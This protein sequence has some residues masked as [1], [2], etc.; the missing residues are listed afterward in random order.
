MRRVFTSISAG[1]I[2]FTTAAIAAAQVLTTQGGRFAIDG[3]PGFLV[4]VS[5]FDALRR[6]PESLDSSVLDADLDYFAASGVSGI[7]V[8]PN[9]HV[10]NETLIDGSGNLRP[11]QLRKLEVLIGRAAAKRLVVDLSLTHDTVPGLTPPDYLRGVQ[12][13]AAALRGRTNVLFDLQ[14]ELDHH[15]P[16]ADARHPE[17]WTLHEWRAFVGNEIKTAVKQADPSRLVTVSW[18]SDR[19]PSELVA[20]L[21]DG[22]YDVL[23]YHHR[24]ESWVADSSAYVKTFESL[25]E[26]ARLERPIYFQEPA[27]RGLAG[28]PAAESDF[29]AALTGARDAGAAAWTLHVPA[30]DLSGTTPFR[31]LVSNT[32]RAVLSK[33]RAALSGRGGR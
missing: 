24:R 16:A 29:L 13:T 31:D 14:N 25:L 9:W 3:Q 15:V 17:Q 30:P 21:R 28:V 12:A 6:I 23:A 5:Y 1:L 27:R 18:T 10:R 22:G 8:F 2:V 32:E 11:V 26:A 20:N 4:F 7:R 19:S 33:L